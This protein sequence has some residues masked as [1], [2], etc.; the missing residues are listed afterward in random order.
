MRPSEPKSL[1]S[2]TLFNKL[3]LFDALAVCMQPKHCWKKALRRASSAGRPDLLTVHRA[4]AREVVLVRGRA[5]L[6]ER[7]GVP[8]KIRVPMVLAAAG[9]RTRCVSSRPS[10]PRLY[11]GA[12]ERRANGDAALFSEKDEAPVAHH[13][14]P[15]LDNALRRRRALDVTSSPLASAKTRHVLGLKLVG[16]T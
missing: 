15:E 2:S 9:P 1:M 6:G 4:D 10:M 13:S 3:G 12:L 16:V 8:T 7:V 11:T 14:G 5:T